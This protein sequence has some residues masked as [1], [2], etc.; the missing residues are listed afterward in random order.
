MKK[1]GGLGLSSTATTATTT[2]TD[3]GNLY[4]MQ[5]RSYQSYSRSRDEA[6]N[7]KGPFHR[8]RSISN[9]S[10]RSEYRSDPFSNEFSASSSSSAAAAGSGGGLGRRNTTGKSLTQSIKRKFGSLRR[11]KQHEER[12]Y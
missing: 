8:Q 6:K 5:P 9:A 1:A 10:P 12:V 2:T 11:K 4:E 3:S 7:G